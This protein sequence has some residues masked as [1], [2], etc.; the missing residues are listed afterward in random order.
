MIQQI[1]KPGGVQSL[2]KDRENLYLISKSINQSS[3]ISASASFFIFRDGSSD[4]V[5]NNPI[6]T[7]FQ[8]A[9]FVDFEIFNGG[10]TSGASYSTRVRVNGDNVA[11]DIISAF[12]NCNTGGYKVVYNGFFD[13]EWDGGFTGVFASVSGSYNNLGCDVVGLKATCKAFVRLANADIN[14]SYL[15]SDGIKLKSF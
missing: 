13:G 2:L 12:N 5:F 10:S 6:G 1:G 15:E 9:G 14:Y 7:S 8:L 11:G 4:R 3:L